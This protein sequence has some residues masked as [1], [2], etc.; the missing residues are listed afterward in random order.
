[1]NTDSDR[2]TGIVDPVASWID[3]AAAA[4]A[5]RDRQFLAS[6]FAVEV[7][8]VEREQGADRAAFLRS[9]LRALIERGRG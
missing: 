1:M 2:N 8:R 7:A 3:F 6:P 5:G 4:A 9:V